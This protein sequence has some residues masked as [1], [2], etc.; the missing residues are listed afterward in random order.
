MVLLT[1]IFDLRV[2]KCYLIFF[3]KIFRVINEHKQCG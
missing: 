3:V 1:S 2:I